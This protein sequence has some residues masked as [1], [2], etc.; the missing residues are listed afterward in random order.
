[1]STLLALLLSL[2]F[3]KPPMP[4]LPP[5][6]KIPVEISMNAVG[7]VTVLGNMPGEWRWSING[8]PFTVVVTDST[9]PRRNHD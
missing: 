9:K 7:V 1:M 8:N 2:W 3:G 6:A 4:P 5:L